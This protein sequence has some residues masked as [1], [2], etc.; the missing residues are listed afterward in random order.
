MKGVMFKKMKIRAKLVTLVFVMSA[1]IVLISFASIF[2]YNRLM[3]QFKEIT[4]DRLPDIV[5]LQIIKEAQLEVSVAERGLYIE[6]MMNM[7]FRNKQYKSIEDAM[8]K[9]Q[10]AIKDYESRPHLSG[11]QAKWKEFIVLYN[12]YLLSHKEFINASYLR[13]GFIEAGVPATDKRMTDNLNVILNVA[14]PCRQTSVDALVKLTELID[15]SH[16]RVSAESGNTIKDSKRILYVLL[17]IIIGS[18]VSGIVIGHRINSNI[19]KILT[20]LINQFHRIVAS[21]LE[22][23]LSSRADVNE[24]NVEFLEIAVGLNDTVDAL[25]NPLNII[26][27]KI[28]DLGKGVVPDKITDQYK[29]DFDKIKMS[30]NNCIDGMQGLVE[31]NRI[32]QK[33]S[34]NDYTEKIDGDF[35]GIYSDVCTAVNLVNDR[36]IHVIEIC[37]RISEGNLSDREDLIKIAKRSEHDRLVPSLILMSESINN[38]I[39]DT[40]SLATAAIEGKLSVRADASKHRGDYG[41]VISGVNNTL[42]AVVGPL[43]VAAD[44]VSR[45]SIGDMPPVITEKYNGD[46]NVIINNLNTLINALNKVIANAKLVAEGD[47]TIDLKRRSENDEL[48]KSFTAMVRSTANIIS[49]FQSASNNISASSQQMS[50]TS[51]QMS[52]GASEQASSAEEVSS[53]MEQMA[54]NI[55]QNT[56]NAQQTEKIAL[57]ASDGISRVNDASDQ[58]LRYMQEIAD[59]VSII[60]EIARQTNILALNAAVEAARAGEHGKGF[61]VVAAEVRKL[62]ER[63]QV[64]A[65]EIDSLTKN[66]VRAT[67]ESGKLLAAIAPEIGKT[68]KLV[69]EIAAASIEQNSGADQVNNAIQQL[70]Q[71]TQQNAAASEEMATSSEELASQAQQLLEMISF[72]KIESNDQGKR[73]LSVVDKSK[74]IHPNAG[75]IEKKEY[76]PHVEMKK[77]HKGV[78]INLGK[79]NLDSNYEKF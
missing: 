51:Q 15:S 78:N 24:T 45:I 22:G 36:V 14:A 72:F 6:K 12:K 50:S 57:N 75:H 63:S 20:S 37:Q 62:A 17:I 33:M 18:Y 28:E 70:N 9:A 69:Q 41:R 29:G 64:S 27:G 65:V 54:A 73:S 46:F 42:D 30:F 55:Q 21:I 34:V 76:K 8:T 16:A 32:L 66:S 56:E 39:I 60:G 59:K 3:K 26:S 31:A 19:Q 11:D 23:D 77:V 47:L 25:V 38:L 61:A 74:V 43:N 2:S 35:S 10:T 58:T 68:A 71:V 44:Y 1:F 79:D 7:E 4:A 49:E 53:S 13:D 40:N 67:E 48:M 5:N 52:Q